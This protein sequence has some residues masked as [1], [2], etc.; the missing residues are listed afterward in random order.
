MKKIIEWVRKHPVISG[1]CAVVAFFLPLL[2]VHFLYQVNFGVK[3]I[4]SAWDAG[5]LLAYIVAFAS[6]ICTG[7]L[8]TIALWQNFKFKKESNQK[9]ELLLH[10]ESEKIRLAHLPQFLIQS[11]NEDRCV[12]TNHQ[13]SPDLSVENVLLKKFDT[14]CFNYN[15]TDPGW[16]PNNKYPVIP[17]EYIDRL[18]SIVN[19]GN[20]SAHQV[21]LTIKIGDKLYASEKTT[22]VPKDKEIFFYFGCSNGTNLP[23]DVSL[24]IRFFDCF[25]NVYEQRFKIK[26]TGDFIELITYT[27]VD[28]V[29]RSS[30]MNLKKNI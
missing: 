3:Q 1:I 11:V 18:Y 23:D 25:Q 15:Q 28:L 16:Q 12:D 26:D 7:I 5:D 22:S 30:V 19:C 17:K 4:E 27:D 20:N 14:Y 10:I 9:D 6:A 21:K 13:L 24:C 29:S 8:S 2:I